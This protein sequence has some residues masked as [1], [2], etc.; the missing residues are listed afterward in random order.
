MSAQFFRKYAD[1][2]AEAEQAPNANPAVQK[3]AHQLVQSLTPEEQQQLQQ[4]AAMAKGKDPKSGGI[5]I[6]KAAGITKQD[7]TSTGESQ[8]SEGI[9]PD[10]KGKIIQA[11]HIA[12]VAAPAISYAAG[13]GADLT[14]ILTML[15]MVAL[16][17]SN[18]V[19]GEEPGQIGSKYDKDVTPTSTRTYL[20]PGVKA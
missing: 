12:S 15:S 16:C 11:L 4:L 6:A 8:M 7:L 18:A 20:K 5:A 19:Y 3:A 17:A 2:I 9:A 10:L 14:G 13:G 1:M